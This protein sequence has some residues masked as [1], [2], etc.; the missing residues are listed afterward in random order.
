M[1]DFTKN[2]NLKIHDTPLFKVKKEA[3]RIQYKFDLD[4]LRSYEVANDDI[5]Y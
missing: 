5:C 3:Y 4:I 2:F 1:K